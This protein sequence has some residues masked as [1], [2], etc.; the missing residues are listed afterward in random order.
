VLGR[1]GD[2]SGLAVILETLQSDDPDMQTEA[3]RAL[4]LWPTSEPKERLFALAEN[5]ESMSRHVLA[6]RGYINMATLAGDQNA[7]QGVQDLKRAWEIARRPDEKRIVLSALPKVACLDA[8]AFAES[9]ARDEDLQAEAQNALVS[10]GK[11]LAK[12]HPQQVRAALQP[13]AAQGTSS[14]VQQ[15]A[16]EVLQQ[17]K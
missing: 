10:L 2:A 1:G 17:L 5:E 6:L 13:L 16:Q 7:E 4:S 8:L 3:I 12:K 14:V 11:V 9:H 15:R